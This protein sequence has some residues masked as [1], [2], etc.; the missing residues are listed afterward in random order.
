MEWGAHAGA[1]PLVKKQEDDMAQHLFAVAFRALHVAART[2]AFSVET[3]ESDSEE[4]I[5]RIGMANLTKACPADQGWTN[6]GVVTARVAPERVQRAILEARWFDQTGAKRLYA[7]GIYATNPV[8]DKGSVI[9]GTVLAC[10]DDRAR[11]MIRKY[12]GIH[13]PA[14]AG[15]R[16]LATAVFEWDGAPHRKPQK[17]RWA[18]PGTTT[19]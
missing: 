7:V 5:V 14:D 1:K 13:Y 2:I 17:D 18:P 6:W 3:V 16:I 12:A 15:W 4:E 9:S 8:T 11:D 19:H 10:N